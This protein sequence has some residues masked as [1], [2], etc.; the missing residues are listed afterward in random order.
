MYI[1]VVLVWGKRIILLARI[2]GLGF[3]P[4]SEYE[5]ALI[6]YCLDNFIRDE[7]VK[8]LNVLYGHFSKLLIRN[9][10]ELNL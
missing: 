7:L 5:F 6:A 1:I 9:L 8:L 10:L 3:K 2:F 4:N